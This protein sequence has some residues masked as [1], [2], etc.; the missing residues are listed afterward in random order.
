MSSAVA[1][2]Q[3]FFSARP[4]QRHGVRYPCACSQFS[5]AVSRSLSRS[6]VLFVVRQFVFRFCLPSSRCC[7]VFLLLICRSASLF[8]C[9]FARRGRFQGI[10][11]CC[12]GCLASSFLRLISFLC[13][14]VSGSFLRF[15]FLASSWLGVARLVF[16]RV[17]FRTSV[18]SSF[19]F[20]SVRLRVWFLFIHR[21][22]NAQMS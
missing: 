18:W 9:L 3:S 1:Q 11:A 22:G 14:R 6:S 21:R 15:G 8:S 5:W 17:S 2:V 4:P 16:P 10:S 19:R 20:A 12:S 7:P 13:P